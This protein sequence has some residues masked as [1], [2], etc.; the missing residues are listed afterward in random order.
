MLIA[1]A[2]KVRRNVS[3]KI[4]QHN[5][6]NKVT[7]TSL[8]PISSVLRTCI[9][10]KLANRAM[11]LTSLDSILRHVHVD[12]ISFITCLL[13]FSNFEN[14][15]IKG[16]LKST[17]AYFDKTLGNCLFTWQVGGV[18]LLTFIFTET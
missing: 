18:N 12:G 4:I 2:V 17:H 10:S 15:I 6:K 7:A 9:F 13:T 8:D 11:N 16:H 3:M 1:F 14:G 5:K